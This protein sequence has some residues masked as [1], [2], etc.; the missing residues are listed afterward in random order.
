MPGTTYTRSGPEGDP[1]GQAADFARFVVSEVEDLRDRLDRESGVPTLIG[2]A[3]MLIG[4]NAGE[5][6]ERLDGYT[7]ADDS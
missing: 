5:I 2:S 7:T 3:L 1:V 6:A 4:M